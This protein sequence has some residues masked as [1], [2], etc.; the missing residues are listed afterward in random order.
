MLARHRLI[1]SVASGLLALA[2]TV[3]AAAQ[4]TETRA[5]FVGTLFSPNEQYE[6]FNRINELFPTDRVAP[7]KKAQPWRKGRPIAL[8]AHIEAQGETLD[9]AQFLR[10]TDTAALL[11]LKDGKIRFE[12][13]WLTGGR[14][15]RWLSMSVAK[16]FVSAMIGIAVAEGRIASIS[17]PVT[18]Y[19]PE[20]VGS[21]YD[22]VSIKDILQM[23]SGVRWTED[24][25]DPKSDVF[26]LAHVMASGSSFAAFPATLSREHAPGT[27]NRY[28]ST[29]TLVLGMLLERATG[30]R[31]AKYMHDRLWEPL[32][33]T[34]EAYW[35]TDDHGMAMAFGGLN[36]T[37]RDFARIG[38]LYRKG[39][40]WGGRQIVPAGWVKASLTSDSSHL[41]PGVRASSDSEM[42]YGYQWWL[43]GFGDTQ[44]YAAIGVYNQFIYVNPRERTVI[45][46]LSANSNYGRTND[47]RSWRGHDHFALFQALAKLK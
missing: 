19:L 22:G 14:N 5:E 43:P 4:R 45:V 39:G 7:S 15:V 10:E 38:E 30:T 42:G 18:K 17:D 9:T 11:V 13:Y 26:G 36:A 37:A 31:L 35:L 1:A 44:D 32:G 33:A 21:G 47:D 2:P 41:M 6:N 12:Q 16:S 20:L 29:D 23:S 8:P 25:S 27:F 28:N 3:P 34:D 24:Y 40:R 46:K